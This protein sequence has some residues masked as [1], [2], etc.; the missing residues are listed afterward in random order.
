MMFTKRFWKAITIVAWYLGWFGCCS[1]AQATPP[2]TNYAPQSISVSGKADTTPGVPKP[3]SHEDPAPEGGTPID[4][5]PQ[6]KDMLYEDWRK[7]EL[8]PGMQSDVELIDRQE[9][10]TFTRELLHAQWR[11]LDPIDLWVIRPAH[12]KNPP[13]IIYLYSYPSSNERYKDPK[14][15]QFLIRNGFAAVG[16]VPALT[17][18]RFHDRPTEQWLVSQLTESLGTTVH[19]VQMVLNY[20]GRRKDLDMNRVGMWGDGAGAT[21]AIVSSAVDARIKALDLLDPWADWPNWLAKS[22]LVPEKERQKYLQAD[23]LEGVG[24]F[25]PIKYLPFVKAE[26]VRLQHID[27]ITV[28][29]AIVREHLEAVTPASAT[30]VHYASSENF[31]KEVGAKGNAFDWLQTQLG[32]SIP[33]RAGGEGT[34]LD[35]GNVSAGRIVETTTE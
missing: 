3:Q 30:I 29:P 12:V 5:I 15:C 4:H 8:T 26:H 24:N 18:H 7:P 20:L 32:P 25:E 17:E 2:A 22:T 34:S 23:F 6:R 35:T 19:D 14:F 31:Y 33:L 1:W 11:E 13:V 21:V 9:E 27:G 10:K 16:F 28:T